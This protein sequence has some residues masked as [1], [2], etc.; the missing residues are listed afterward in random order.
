[1]HGWDGQ[2]PTPLGTTG[3]CQHT[4]QRPTPLPHHGSSRAARSLSLS[5]LVTALLPLM[6]DE[7]VPPPA[8]EPAT[9]PEPATS[10]KPKPVKLIVR[11]LPPKLTE[12]EFKESIA[13]FFKEKADAKKDINWMRFEPGRLPGDSKTAPIVFGC[14]YLRFSSPSAAV[15]FSKLKDGAAYRD[16]SGG[17]TR[18]LVE[19][20]TTQRIPNPR[21][22]KPDARDGTILKDPDYLKFVEE[23]CRWPTLRALCPCCRVYVAS[24]QPRCRR[25]LRACASCAIYRAARRAAAAS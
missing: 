9:E 25:R 21:N 22:S 8:A 3:Q 23:V 17:M 2:R 10:S 5:D 4:G 7:V 20:A 18:C 12:A 6:A 15:A 24:M 1:M 11:M 13:D 14:A 19:V 16:A